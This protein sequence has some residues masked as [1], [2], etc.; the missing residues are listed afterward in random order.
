MP[1]KLTHCSKLMSAPNQVKLLP[2]EPEKKTGL[3]LQIKHIFNIT[4][5]KKAIANFFHPSPKHQEIINPTKTE[6]LSL[7]IIDSCQ[8][9][10]EKEKIEYEKLVFLSNSIKK[11]SKYDKEPGIF[12]IPGNKKRTGLILKYLK[13]DK[14]ITSQ[15]IVH[16]NISISDLTSAYKQH[17]AALFTKNHKTVEKIPQNL[18]EKLDIRS[19]PDTFLTLDKTPLSLQLAVLF[20]AEIAE[21]K[22]TTLMNAKNL[23]ICIAPNFTL[24]NSQLSQNSSKKKPDSSV[25]Q[26]EKLTVL[27]PYVETLIKNEMIQKSL[28]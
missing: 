11:H 21:N 23:A 28:I 17:L 9:L 27:I 1:F 7:K 26:L 25:S 3:A 20:L 10:N 15:F 4:N 13:N 8:V 19:F 22:K 24:P 14:P 2:S 5:F 16:N 6:Q 12:R 18:P